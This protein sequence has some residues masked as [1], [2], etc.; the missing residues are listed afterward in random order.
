MH[1]AEEH[2]KE[3]AK[4]QLKELHSQRKFNFD[5]K[6]KTG[7][8]RPNESSLRPVCEGNGKRIDQRTC[9][10]CNESGFIL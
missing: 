4:K 10:K 5:E 2:K 8:W 6:A 7:D 1:M 9:S 3:H